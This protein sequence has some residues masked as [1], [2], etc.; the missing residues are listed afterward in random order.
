MSGPFPAS[1]ADWNCAALALRSRLV[2]TTLTLVFGW[3]FSYAAAAWLRNDV[4]V[5]ILPSSR[6]WVSMP[7][8]QITSWVLPSAAP[9]PEQPARPSAR[10]AAARSASERPCLFISSLSVLLWMRGS[11]PCA[12]SV[13]S[14][15]RGQSAIDGEDLTRDVGV[16]SRGQEG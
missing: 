2:R 1:E 10:L 11:G 14:E 7:G 13:G 3:D 8:S 9:P 4:F 6:T 16:L 12:G 5:S 15:G